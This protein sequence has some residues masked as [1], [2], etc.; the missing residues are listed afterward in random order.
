MTMRTWHFETAVVASVL[1]VVALASGG[2]PLEMVGA[3]A[4][5]LSFGHASVGERLRE[6][7]A[8]RTQP[9]VECHRWSTRYFVG[10]EALWLVYFVAH[11]A[12]SA[13]VG[14]GMFLG[15]PAWRRF[16]RSR[17]PL[18]PKGSA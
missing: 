6:R 2:G 7:E 18:A 12:W 16:W 13:L 4:V 10:K 1:L 15:Y 8:A 11:G 17:H 3:C 9:S 14:V 5:L